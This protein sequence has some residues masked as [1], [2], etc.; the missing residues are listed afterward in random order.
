MAG[1]A[2]LVPLLAAAA[3]LLPLGPYA[4]WLAVASGLVAAGRIALPL[5]TGI[6]AAETE[7]L[8][9]AEPLGASVHLG[10]DGL[11]GALIV[12]VGLASAIGAGLDGEARAPRARAAL[13]CLLQAG[14]TGV[15][16]SRDLLILFVFWEALLVPLMLLLAGSHRAG[17]ERPTQRLAIQALVADGLLLAGIIALGVGARSFDLSRL[18]GYRLAPPS[19]VILAVLF[20][21]AFAVRLPLFPLHGW[22]GR[23]VGATP[24]SV[25]LL[26]PGVLAPAAVYGLELCVA[27]FP[28]G[29]AFLAPP[30]V[31]LAV[32]GALYGATVALRQADARG[33]IAF[34]ALAQLDLVALGVFVGTGAAQQGALLA[35]LSPGLAV[36]AVLVIASSGPAFRWTERAVAV[37]ALVG[38]PGT[39][40]FA[41]TVLILSGAIERFG[42]AT[43]LAAGLVVLGA[44]DG[45]RLYRLLGLGDGPN[46]KPARRRERALVAA[47]LLA[48]VVLGV[49]PRAVTDLVAPPTAQSAAR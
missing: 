23:T 41:G 29:M 16:L 15:L 33:V 19:Q 7:V 38:L 14:V 28:A 36:P 47:L 31:A 40:A 11:S 21:G 10:S 9:W 8:T 5:W 13:R 43:A 4:R 37:A 1:D 45:A 30:L 27:L 17:D 24:P 3:C 44:L 20:V 2:L 18:I 26:I 6:G 49:A 32:A 25:A 48:V 42:A 12:L 34:A 46:G 22:L 39:G 35:T